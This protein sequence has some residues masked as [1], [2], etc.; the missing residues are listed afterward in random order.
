MSGPGKLRIYK[1]RLTH[2]IEKNGIHR[3]CLT[4]CRA[5]ESI[6][7]TLLPPLAPG[8]VMTARIGSAAKSV[9]LGGK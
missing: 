2:R 8:H 7:G 4:Q 1:M 3:Y 9:Y 6:H 5:F